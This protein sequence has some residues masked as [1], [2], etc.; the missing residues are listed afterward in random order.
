ME[1]RT[2]LYINGELPPDEKR[3]F[4]EELQHSA[5]LQEEV[6]N[7]RLLVGALNQK[8]LREDIRLAELR[9]HKERTKR[10]RWFIIAGTVALLFLT[11]FFFRTKTAPVQ[12][13]SALPQDSTPGLPSPAA[14]PQ[15]EVTPSTNPGVNTSKPIAQIDPV[16][17]ADQPRYRNLPADAQL[18]PDGVALAD[19]FL[20][21]FSPYPFINM[22]GLN[23]LW[24]AGAYEN[25]LN[26]VADLNDKNLKTSYSPD[27]ELVRAACFLHL[28][29]PAKASSLLDPLLAEKEP[30]R[31]EAT[32]LL[33]LCYVM[34][35]KDESAAA[36]LAGIRGKYSKQ[37]KAL[38]NELQ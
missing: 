18:P 20:R 16:K 1:F 4:E 27:V 19:T 5:A 37:A 38:L 9:L 11:F 32:W 25:Y 36:A 15:P 26:L 23:T 28:H 24:E 13:P 10:L 31:T 6:A 22:A 8:K 33:S 12:A 14:H 2:D 34:Q 21:A 17:K 3:R 7:M 30:L 29:Q 35:G